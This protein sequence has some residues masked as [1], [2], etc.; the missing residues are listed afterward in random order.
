[1]TTKQDAKEAEKIL[2]EWITDKTGTTD[3]HRAWFKIAYEMEKV[4][5]TFGKIALA[6]EKATTNFHKAAQRHKN[7][8]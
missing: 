7:D 3:F 1:M 8:Y 5:E 4:G 2:R 6:A